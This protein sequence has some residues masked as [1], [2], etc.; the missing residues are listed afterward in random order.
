MRPTCVVGVMGRLTGEALAAW[1]VASCA[2]QGVPAKVTDPYVLGQVGA[3]LTG[4][5]GRTDPARSA[6]G[7]HRAGRSQ[8][9][10]GR[11]P[12][13]VQLAGSPRPGANHPVVQH[14]PDDRV[15]PGQVQPAPR[16]A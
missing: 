7:A 6:G 10:D 4:R 5:A 16:C 15:L 12:S 11:D 8:P 14:R 1:V 13:G 3:L 9:P 2:A